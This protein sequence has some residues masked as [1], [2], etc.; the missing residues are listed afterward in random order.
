MD[1]VSFANPFFDQ[2]TKYAVRFAKP[3]FFGQSPH[4]WS[5]AS[6]RNGTATLLKLRDRFLGVTCQHVLDG[7]RRL[8]AEAPDTVFY[9]GS[10]QF[11][12]EKHLICED[13]DR[14]LAILDLA[15]YVSKRGDLIESDFVQPMTWPPQDVSERDVLC[16]AGFPG[17]WREQLGFGH[18]RF[19][20]F[21]T[22]TAPVLSVR[23]DKIVTTIQI[24]D[25]LTQINGG[26]IWGSL[27]GL[28]GGPVFVWRKTP[29]LVAELVGFIYEYQ[30]SL[31]LLFVRLAKVI[32]EDGTLL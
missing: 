23:D 22:G 16:L 3:V 24:Q 20:S 30:E 6:L 4:S 1:L 8:K 5:T 10:V 9:F 27:G 14:D 26:K 29:I 28:S 32:G 21:N 7:Y 13:R 12:A 25:C 18:L 19:Y 31:D 17:I 2:M 11:D 15:S